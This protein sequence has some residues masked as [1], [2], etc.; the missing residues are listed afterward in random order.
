MVW[1]LA[2]NQRSEIMPQTPAGRFTGHPTPRRP[3]SFGQE[4]DTNYEKRSAN[5]LE[6]IAMYLDHIEI[7]LG[8]I[9][10]TAEKAQISVASLDKTLQ[11]IANKMP[12]R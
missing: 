7:Q 5:A 10:D 2:R 12:T 1:S 9:A 4:G 11:E 8:H 6:Y 3:W